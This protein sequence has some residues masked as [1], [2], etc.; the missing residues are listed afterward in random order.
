METTANKLE[1]ELRKQAAEA[2]KGQ[3]AAP[4]AAQ[5]EPEVKPTDGK[6]ADSKP[7]PDAKP[8]EAPKP[9]DQKPA[10]QETPFAKAK[11]DKDRHR[12]S[13]D[14]L[15]REK[16]ALKKEREDFEKTRKSEQAQRTSA[17]AARPKGLTGYSPEELE[18]F[19]REFDE[20]GRSDMA[21]AARAEAKRAREAQAI[22]R[23]TAHTQAAEK[24]RSEQEYFWAEA[25]K[26]FGE[27]LAEGSPSR[28]K[29]EEVFKEGAEIF[30]ARGIQIPPEWHWHA[31]SIAKAR[32]AEARVPELEKQITE[33]QAEIARLRDG[34]DILPGSAT[35]PTPPKDV[36]EMTVTELEAHLRAQAKAEDRRAA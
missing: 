28:A 36:N 31:V 17:E 18:Q 15:E 14:E 30:N 27:I 34:R 20:E 12:R 33:L 24:Y 4:E 11:K 23:Q 5:P 26:E 25:Q 3:P 32:L 9:T 16:E 35:V 6:V 1:A 7:L 22:E 13:W 19:A 21:Q 2:D 10:E 29:A 8:V